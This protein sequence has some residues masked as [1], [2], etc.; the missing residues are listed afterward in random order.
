MNEM[1]HNIVIDEDLCTGCGDCIEYCHV[2]AI[3]VSEESGV[4]QV[5]DLDICIECHMCQQH[6]PQGAIKV[7]PQLED[8][9]KDMR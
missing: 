4:V 6:C 9:M 3:E 5:V 1:E 2:D 8:A 7:Y